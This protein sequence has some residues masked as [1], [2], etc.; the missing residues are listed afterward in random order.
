MNK[1]LKISRCYK[2]YNKNYN[3]LLQ[4]FQNDKFSNKSL[5]NLYLLFIRLVMTNIFSTVTIVLNKKNFAKQ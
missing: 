2:K 1:F 4:E 3:K 5:S